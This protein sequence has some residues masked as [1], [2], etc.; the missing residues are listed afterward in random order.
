[1]LH[2]TDENAVASNR[3]FKSGG[4]DGLCGVKDTIRPG[5]GKPLSKPAMGKSQS[6]Q[7]TR[8]ALC[9][10]TNSMKGMPVSS[11]KLLKSTAKTV[12]EPPVEH[13]AGKGWQAI[14]EEMLQ[15]R[16]TELQQR[17]DRIAASAS[18]WTTSH[19]YQED[20]S[21][22]ETDSDGSLNERFSE[23]P[24]IVQLL[25][26]RHTQGVTMPQ[27]GSGFDVELYNLLPDVPAVPIDLGFCWTDEEA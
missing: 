21:D 17:L 19:L 10:L 22:D 16:E 4:G 2:V 15:Q 8:T 11:N 13:L 24:V 23:S 27:P 14:E 20:S 3:T 1:M 26:P 7:K 5:F 9:D 18:T 6:Q 25:A 12:P